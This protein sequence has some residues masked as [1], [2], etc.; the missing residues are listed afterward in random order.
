MK[1]QLLLALVLIAG[2]NASSQ[3]INLS[4]VKQYGG[5]SYITPKA[6]A[7]DPSGAIITCGTLEGLSDFNPGTGSNTTSSNGMKDAYIA[8]INADGEY[9]WAVSFGSTQDDIAYDVAVDVSGNVYCTG[10]FRGTVDF[11]QLGT[12]ANL[13]AFS[14]YNSFVV[15]WSVDGVFQ[16]AKKFGGTS[17]GYE[18][19]RAIA[20]DGSG[21]VISSGIFYGTVDFDPG[22]GVTEMN[23]NNYYAT[24]VSKLN[25]NGD[26][27]WAKGFNGYYTTPTE[28]KTDDNN[29]IFCVGYFYDNVDFN[30][31]SGTYTLDG[32]YY[33]TYITKL[34]PQGNFVWAKQF[35]STNY[36]WTNEIQ[37]GNDGSV[38]AVG[39]FNG[40]TDF[41]PDLVNTET[42]TNTTYTYRPFLV[43][44]DSDGLFQ[45]VKQ[46]SPNSTGQA[47]GL[48][49][50]NDGNMYIAGYYHGTSDFDPDAVNEFPMSSINSYEDIF[51]TK[52][53]ANGNFIIAKSIGGDSN[54]YVT[55]LYVNPPSGM[56]IMTGYFNSTCDFDPSN[57]A[58]NL[59]SAGF[60]DAFIARYVQC[61]AITE[62]LEASACGSYDFNGFIY[63]QSGTYEHVLTSTMGCDSIVTL[64]LIIQGDSYS[65]VTL[66]TTDAIEYNGITYSEEGSY[67]QELESAFGCD[68]IIYIQVD[69]MEVNFNVQNSG[70][71][72]SGNQQG[73]SYQWVDCNNNNAPI[74]GATSSTYTP[75]Q[76]GSFALVVYGNDGSVMSDCI[77]VFI[78]AVEQN[79]QIKVAIYPNPASDRIQFSNAVNIFQSLEI[80]SVNGDLV[81]THTLTSG[82]QTIMI[83]HLPLGVYFV[84]LQG[85]KD[86]VVKLT[87]VM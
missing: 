47:V 12:T 34:D 31:G 9:A 18:S 22:A 17:Q 52:L 24:Y 11:N 40:T 82:S 4:W 46:L 8:K 49:R 37:I 6:S 41:D 74:A 28:M 67:T 68:S 73:I 79:D 1:S 81:S 7:V 20:V 53:D 30:P 56:L 33:D 65:N 69:I 64:N 32:Q 21:N 36:C 29:N 54:D 55:G 38:Y 61:D 39:G 71:T 42:V 77:E 59:T 80:Y 87:R 76:S 15:K 43:K 23:F 14:G 60:S 2:M 62:S 86:T 50:D 63:T 19:G 83:D 5:P 78:I 51:I 3:S 16:W 57:E 10:E 45:Y 58:V 44:L 48:G 84:R 35:T 13:T 27:V 25:A 72:L 66:Y 85:E 26:F 75:T 70:G